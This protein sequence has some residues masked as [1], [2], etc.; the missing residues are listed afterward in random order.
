MVQAR[1]E[2]RLEVQVVAGRNMPRRSRFGRGDTLVA[3]TL[4]TS[5]KQT[6]VDKKGGAAPKWNDRLS[7]LVSGLGKSQLH[8]TAYEMESSVSQKKIGSC[9]I[10][11]T[12]IF[13]EEEVD[14]WYTL[15]SNE[16]P[17]G[18][19]YLEFTYTPKGGRK[20]P[21]KALMQD[22]EDDTPFLLEPKQSK[23]SNG[24]VASAPAM[25]QKDGRPQSVAA[26]NTTT[27]ILG[28]AVA[29][30]HL[31][32]SMS[33]L[34][35]YSSASM[36]TPDLANKYAQMHGKK[37]LPAAPNMSAPNSGFEG[38][39]SGGFQSQLSDY[40]QTM[41]PGQLPFAQQRPMS[42][43]GE[44]LHMQYQGA[45]APAPVPVQQY[46]QQQ[47]QQL[48]TLFAPPNGPEQPSKALPGRPAPAP[49]YNPTFNP[50]YNSEPAYNSDP[51]YNPAYNPGFAGDADPQ[52]ALQQQ[53]PTQSLLPVP[54]NADNGR[55][56]SAMS[57]APQ[58][59]PMSQMAGNPM[60]APQ[61]PMQYSGYAGDGQQHVQYAGYAY[62]SM[63]VQ[64]T[65]TSPV[66]YQNQPVS[67]YDPYMSAQPYA[68]EAV[69]SQAAFQPQY[70]QTQ[71]Q[72][73]QPQ[74]AQQQPQMVYANVDYSQQQQQQM[75]YAGQPVY[76]D[77]SGIP[78][79]NVQGGYMQPP[80]QQQQMYA[81]GN[82]YGGPTY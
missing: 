25:M 78:Y 10:D 79:S 22:E 58:P 26:I 57:S 67:A 81:P 21:P 66:Q 77:Q 56:Q 76:V 19:I 75:M 49:A 68:P 61:Q 32:P 3:M 5:T 11:L 4:G 71:P 69:M 27:P 7:F 80:Q 20:Q 2:G 35:P 28:S 51:A 64:M 53:Q 74:Y 6:Q 39:Y 18:D 17:A 63:P 72:L 65:V 55:P 82:T 60:Y 8:V 37:P 40:D 13:I 15:T 48:M 62:G 44:T 73:Q 38:G 31:Q 47:Q 12:R 43:S 33:D 42:Y 9:V 23:S 36:H 16:K 14:G 34:R 52:M 30:A 50:G 45:M 1:P 24:T 46:P 59:I 54:L 41:M 70:V 29:N